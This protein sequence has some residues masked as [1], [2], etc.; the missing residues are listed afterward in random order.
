MAAKPTTGK[1]TERTQVHAQM[2]AM[3]EALMLGSVRQHELTEAADSS[4]A[5]LQMEI[6]ERKQTEEALRESEKR[7]RTLFDL[8]PVAVY[9]CDALG[10]IQNFNRRAAELWG[11]KP[12]AR[13]TSERFCGSFKLFRPNGSFMP[14]EQCPVAE[15]VSGK[16]TA[17][18]GTEVL[19]ERSDGSRITV[20]VDI[21]PLKNK[22]G[23]VTGA[24]NYFYDIT[25]LKQAEEARRRIAVMTATNQRLELEIAQRHAVEKALKQSEQHQSRLLEESRLMQDQL[26]LLSRQLLSAQEGERKRISRELHDVIAQSLSSISVRLA[27]LQKEVALDPEGA[28]RSIAAAQQLVEKSV[29]IVH[30]FARELRPTMLDDLGLIPALHA[31]MKNFKEETGIH[32]SLSAFAAIEQVTGDRRI[33]FYRVAQEALTNVA[34]HAQASRVELSIEKVDGAVC[35]K[36]KDNGKGFPAERVFH[37]KKNQ[38]LGLLG[39]RER[40]EMV[41]GNFTIQSVQGKGTTITAQIPLG[42]AHVKTDYAALTTGLPQRIGQR[43]ESAPEPKAT[44]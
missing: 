22:Q 1:A 2:L 28:E 29:N 26:Q 18:R 8:G 11:R 3:N 24:I 9:S 12:V 32:V 10:V 4:N 20:V 16:K 35:M 38:R 41:G 36:I 5:L 7:Y 19:I 43:Q 13:D 34:R 25:E 21:R 39:M 42:K 17:V 6:I 31:F 15:V 14:H 40:L 44:K 27:N 23:K 30:Q 37:A 33:V